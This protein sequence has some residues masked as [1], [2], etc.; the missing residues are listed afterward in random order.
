MRTKNIVRIALVTGLVLLA[1]FVAMQFTAEVSWSLFDFVVAGSLLFGTGLAY[2][3]L[4]KKASVTAYKAAVG[5]AVAAAFLLTWINLAVGMIGSEDNP[6]NL[7]YFGVLGVGVVGAFIA[8]LQP[9]GMSRALFATA[10]AQCVVA[11]IAV[12]ARFGYPKNTPLQI[13]TLNCMFAMLFVASG[14]LFRRASVT[15]SP[16]T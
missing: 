10:L 7:M 15:G 8:R 14:L 1:N 13:L 3:L 6:A 16:L 5:I 12:A 11:L 9:H 4:S 2:E